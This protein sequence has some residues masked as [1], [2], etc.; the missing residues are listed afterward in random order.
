MKKYG[1]LYDLIKS[2]SKSEKRF[3]K[4]YATPYA[5]GDKNNYIKLFN[6]IDAL[7][8]YDEG[9][10]SKII[11]SAS[12]TGNLSSM[13]N[14]LYYLVLDCLDIYH[15]DSSVDRVMSKYV[16]IARVLSEKGLDEQSNRIIKKAKKLSKEHN[17]FG[18]I[19]ALN[20]I[21]QITAFTREDVSR[22][23]IQA[24]YQES[25]SAMKNMR[26][27]LR[28]KITYEE[29]WIKRLRV[30]LVTDPDEKR[31]LKFTYNTSFLNKQPDSNSFDVTMYYLLSKIEYYRILFNRQK[32]APLIRK[33]IALFENNIDEIEDNITQYIYT[34]NVFITERVYGTDRMEAN[35]VLKKIISAPA[36]LKK[37][38]APRHI[39]MQIFRLYYPLVFHIALVFRD[40]ESAFP[41]IQ[42]YEMERNRLENKFSSSFHYC[43]Q[44]NI[45]CVYFGAGD[46]KRAL[47]CCNE[48]I[49][50]S[51]KF[52]QDIMCGM[53]ILNLLIHYEL[54]N[55]IILPGLLKSAYN[56]L[57]KI[58]RNDPV[59]LVLL[60]HIHLL[61]LDTSNAEQSLV[62]IQLRREILLIHKRQE[63]NIFDELDLFGW[64][65]KNVERLSL[66]LTLPEK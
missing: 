8:K 41:Y 24:Y 18:N 17:R 12:F 43:I 40:Y 51:V 31:L 37:K 29:L 30:G 44:A 58:K 28:Y 38:T 32:G 26:I 60:N 36:F 14:Y 33:L 47:R 52:R 35:E 16:N 42:K 65:D 3:I 21:Q 55:R 34:L 45:A 5:R 63:A 4:I 7:K 64:I 11:K 22:D 46:Y 13:K 10:L 48:V 2:L 57:Q 15:K 61:L 20:S 39:S 9:K 19:V 49:N 59:L 54:G 1:A 62:F 66:S 6:F 25:I 56:Y 23:D 53:Y 50:E 27:K